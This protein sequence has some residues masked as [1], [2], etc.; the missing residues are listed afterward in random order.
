MS[1]EEENGPDISGTIE[2]D[3]ALHYRLRPS[4]RPAGV[5]A[6]LLIMLHGRGANEGDIYELVPFV[7]REIMVVA[8]RAPL[9]WDDSPRGAFQWFTWN[10][11]IEEDLEPF[12]TAI[13]SLQKL[14]DELMAEYAIDREQIYFGGFSQGAAMSCLLAL[15][16]PELV[17]GVISHSGFLP[18]NPALHK[19]L[20]NAKDKPFLVLQ[21]TED[22]VVIVRRAQ[23]LVRLLESGG[24]NVTYEE[25]PIA[26][27][28]NTAS[29]HA[30]AEWL[31]KVV[32]LS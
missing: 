27:A 23:E 26:H 29:R 21:G 32:G 15:T 22:T 10:P 6:P 1:V 7:N 17:K 2:K 25:F 24:A 4:T 18:Y 13:Q 3:G 8:P 9:R 12:Q 11:E 20:V 14:L 5:P 16:I 19:A 31:H 30:L 28:T